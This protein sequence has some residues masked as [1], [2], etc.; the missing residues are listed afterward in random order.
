MAPEVRSAGISATAEAAIATSLLA[1]L[2]PAAV[3]AVALPTVEVESPFAEERQV[4]ARASRRRRTEFLSGRHCARLALER[5]GLPPS[6]IV[7]GA[8]GEPSWPEGIV[9]SITHTEQLTIAAVAA[10]TEV[11]RLGIDSELAD[12]VEPVACA[13]Q[14]FDPLEMRRLMSQSRL[15]LAVGFSAKE[16]LFK[17]LFP[18]VGEYF[19]FLDAGVL[20]DSGREEF[21]LSLLRDLAPSERAGD[22]YRGRFGSTGGHVITAICVAPGWEGWAAVG[23]R[24]KWPPGSTSS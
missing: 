13:G 4:V 23:R 16:A 14:V 3:T 18:T 22:R 17:A 9:G 20:L 2:L 5:T 15:G 24:V 6:P 21:E 10:A 1:R 19:D 8:S 12:R 11:E 7:Q